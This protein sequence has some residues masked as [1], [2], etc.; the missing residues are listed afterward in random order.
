[1]PNVWSRNNGQTLSQPV[2]GFADQKNADQRQ[3]LDCRSKSGMSLHCPSL[4]KMTLK[5]RM[6]CRHD[7]TDERRVKA[8]EACSRLSSLKVGQTLARHGSAVNVCG[9]R[10]AMERDRM[11]PTLNRRLADGNNA[12]SG[13]SWRI[14]RLE[15]A[16]FFSRGAAPIF[17]LRSHPA[18]AAISSDYLA[19]LLSRLR[20]QR[21]TSSIRYPRSRLRRSHQRP[22]KSHL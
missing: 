1:M 20:R 15:D 17:P 21:S 10:V 12:V 2:A 8:L 6:F 19:K 3:H 22:S 11:P 4:I 9:S 16:R 5:S 13:S 7:E 18:I 14:L